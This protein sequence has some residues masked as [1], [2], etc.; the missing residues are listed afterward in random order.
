MSKGRDNMSKKMESGAGFRKKIESP[1]QMA[2]KM[3]KAL[4]EGS[5]DEFLDKELPENERARKLARLMSGWQE[6]S[7]MHPKDVE[8]K[9]IVMPPG[10]EPP[11]SEQEMIDQLT[12]IASANDLSLDWLIKRALK[13]YISEYLQ[14]GR[15]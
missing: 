4:A 12:D 15:L 1:F 7:G 11:M 5:L 14:T 9:D 6:R 3:A 13:V 10:E 8:A 2:D